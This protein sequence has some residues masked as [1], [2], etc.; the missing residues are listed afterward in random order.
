MRTTLTI[1]PDVAVQIESLRR[2]RDAGLKEIVNEALRLGLQTMCEAPKQ[3]PFR[4]RPIRGPQPLFR[5]MDNISE[6]LAMVEG[7]LYK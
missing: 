4:T 2:K 5:R 1:D 7:D 3:K 6:I